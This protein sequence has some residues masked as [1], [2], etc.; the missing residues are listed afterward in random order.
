MQP[1][2]LSS[3]FQPIVSLT[4]PAPPRILESLARF[5]DG[6]RPDEVFRRAHAAGYGSR[7]ELA[8]ASAHLAAAAVL[9][10]EIAV[11]VN[12]STKVISR[13]ADA[14]AVLLRHTHA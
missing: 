6:R 1:V 8:A 13:H 10:P 5:S 14:L 11:S 7:L 12:F 2:H 4:D 9:P 3:L